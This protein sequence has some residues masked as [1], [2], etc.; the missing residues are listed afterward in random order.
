MTTPP[1]PPPADQDRL[2]AECPNTPLV[3]LARIAASRPDLHPL[4]AVNPSTYPD[5]LTWLSQSTDPAVQR[6]LQQRN[7]QTNPNTTQSAAV[8]TQAVDAVRL[9]LPGAA[10]AFP[11]PNNAGPGLTLTI[12]HGARPRRKPLVVVAAVVVAVLAAT[13][14]YATTHNRSSDANVRNLNDLLSPGWANGT[15]ERWRLDIGP[16]DNAWVST[17]GDQLIVARSTASANQELADFAHQ[18]T[19]SFSQVTAYDITGSEPAKQWQTKL[20]QDAACASSFY[21]CTTTGFWGNYVVVGDTLLASDDGSPTRAPW[22]DSL[23]TFGI[24]ED[25]IFAC[26]KEGYCSGWQHPNISSPK[27]TSFL[28][29]W[30]VRD[31]TIDGDIAKWGDRTVAQVKPHQAIDIQSGEVIELHADVDHEQLNSSHLPHLLADGWYFFREET[32]EDG[33][34]VGTYVIMSAQ[35]D[36]TATIDGSSSDSLSTRALSPMS[37][38]TGEQLRSVLAA[39]DA[40]WSDMWIEVLDEAD[41]NDGITGTFTISNGANSW[42]GTDSYGVISSIGWHHNERA[43]MCADEKLFVYYT[44]SDNN[45]APNIVYVVPIDDSAI[46]IDRSIASGYLV[47]PELVVSLDYEEWEL[48]ALAPAS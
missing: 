31:E 25:I 6:A 3:E 24:D 17:A 21:I 47:S 44:T 7:T 26:E 20:T 28:S 33:A 27:W 19:V 12:P 9:P 22:S 10:S 29:E 46:T 23:A 11:S 8:Q 48:V 37:Q 34:F 13:T 40:S 5:L 14:I 16:Y 4:L 1:P 43:S 30:T 18:E 32:V 38:W 39:S 2:A 41:P 15:S 45:V 42:S 36:I 35:G